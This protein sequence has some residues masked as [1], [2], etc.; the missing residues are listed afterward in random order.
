MAFS[1]FKTIGEVLKAFQIT[2]TEANFVSELAFTIPDYFREDLELMM[3]DAVVDNSEFAICEN[4]IYPILKEVW[5]TYRSKFILWSHQS[6]NYDEKLSGFPEYILAKRSPLGKVVFDKPYFILVEA[7][8]DNFETGWAQCL[9]EM[10]AA[11]RLN[12]EY[13]IVIF[14]I[15]SNG[16]RWQFGKLEGEI[17][18]RNSTFYTIQEL[19][20]LFATVNFVFQQCEI[21]LNNL[22]AA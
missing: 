14:G 13:Q 12:G 5:K 4:L 17:F 18:T 21:Q 6:L 9:A 8:Q 20:K 2:Y 7:K 16:D 10:I 15:V 11:Q 22:V 1:S 3:R 19:D